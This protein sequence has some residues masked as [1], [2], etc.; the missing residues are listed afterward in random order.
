MKTIG[1]IGGVTWQSTSDYY[2]TINTAISRRLGGAHSARLALV[3]LDFAEV[4]ACMQAGDEEAVFARYLDA[5][6]ALRRCEA[7]FMVLCSNTAH[8]RADRLAEAAGLPLLH[9]GDATGTAVRRAGLATI[10]LLG[11]RSTMEGDFI[12]GRLRTRHGLSVLVPEEPDRREIDRLIYT[13]MSAGVFSDHARSVI[14]DAARALAERGAQGLILGCTELP[15]LMRGQDI[16]VPAFD[17]AA[18]HASAAA[19]HALEENR[20]TP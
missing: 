8:R 2:R 15:I 13:E 6:T 18:L 16:G 11:T 19:D 4:L 10:G 1:L 7:D 9:I 12:A 5:A 3:S 20:D 14:A 17:T